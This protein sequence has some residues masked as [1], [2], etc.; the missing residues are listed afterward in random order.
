MGG[1]RL[2]AWSGSD[3]KFVEA[4]APANGGRGCGSA[5]PRGEGRR[6]ET[7]TAG[8]GGGAVLGGR[9]VR[10]IVFLGAAPNG[11][12]AVDG[13]VGFGPAVA[14]GP[15]GGPLGGN[16]GGTL[17]PTGAPG[18]PFAGSGILGGKAAFLGAGSGSPARGDTPEEPGTGGSVPLPSAMVC[19]GLA[20]WTGPASFGPFV[21]IRF[22]LVLTPI[23]GLRTSFF[24]FTIL[25]MIGLLILR[26]AHP[27]TP[28]VARKLRGE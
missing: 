23:L 16:L 5:A 20:R 28:E 2:T 8:I 26:D 19:A 11:A 9:S 4:L 17:T 12:F 6:G 25:R 18:G 7:S 1:G 24:D 15:L 13:T 22:A 21:R 27:K 14:G 3:G 10:N